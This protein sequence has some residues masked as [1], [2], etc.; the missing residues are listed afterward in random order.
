MKLEKV[1]NWGAR[2]L[3]LAMILLVAQA[4]SGQIPQLGKVG[5]V[6]KTKLDKAK[7]NIGDVE[8]RLAPLAGSNLNPFSKKPQEYITNTGM[9]NY[10]DF[11]KKSAITYGSLP[12]SQSFITDAQTSLK[13][14]AMDHAATEEAKKQLA[15]LKTDKDWNDDE[16]AL[17]KK[18][19]LNKKNKIKKSEQENFG[20]TL[21][22]LTIAGAALGVS[23]KNAGDLIKQGNSLVGSAKTDFSGSNALLAPGIIDGLKDSVDKLK[24]VPDEGAKNAKAISQLSAMLKE[25]SAEQKDAK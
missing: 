19:A 14:Y 3:V 1:F 2:V 9:S 15:D 12:V 11:F 16:M 4:G 25:L 22:N 23:T 5:K 10:D 6:G 8:L 17:V 18:T 7:L 24:L 13:K 21:G 20:K